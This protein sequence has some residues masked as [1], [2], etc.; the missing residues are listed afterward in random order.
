MTRI[1][2][3][4][5]AATG[6]REALADTDQ[7]DGKVSLPSGWTP[8]YE[9]GDTDPNYRPVGREEMNGALFEI[10]ESLGEIQ[11]YGFA[12]WRAITGGW[13]LNARTVFTDGVIYKSTVAANTSTPGSSSTWVADG[14]DPTLIR[15]LGMPIGTEFIMDMNAPL[16]P[17]D[18]SRYRYII[19]SAGLTGAGQY[20]EGVLTGEIVTGSDPNITATA[21]I[22]LSG[23]PLNGKTQDLINTSRAFPRPGEASGE[24]IN[25][26]LLSH[27]HSGQANYAGDHSHPYAPTYGSDTDRGTL[28]S[29]FSIDGLGQT[30]VAGGHTHNVSITATGGS[31]SAPRHIH[32]VYMK[33]IM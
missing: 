16:P 11:Q 17:K 6:D 21:V 25:S 19:L 26:T 23:S 14:V 5:F 29:L 27:S 28:S 15:W 10:T 30:G 2:K 1:F 20:N 8:D 3:T 9:L 4:A 24:I 7:P 31:E 22:S 33:R 32:R 12:P 13:P 18:D